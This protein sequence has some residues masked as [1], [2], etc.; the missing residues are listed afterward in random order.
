MNTWGTYI[1]AWRRLKGERAFVIYLWANGIYAK[2]GCALL[3]FLTGDPLI[4]PLGFLY[5]C[6]GTPFLP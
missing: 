3:D 4:G 5:S 2:T 6:L 1:T